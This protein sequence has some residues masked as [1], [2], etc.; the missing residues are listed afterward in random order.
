M[1]GRFYAIG[2]AVYREAREVRQQ[3]TTSLTM[4][5]KVCEVCDGVNPLEVARF[6]NLGTDDNI[7]APTRAP[8]RALQS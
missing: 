3:G 6:L 4:G 5:F 1:N 2:R 8:A 7:R